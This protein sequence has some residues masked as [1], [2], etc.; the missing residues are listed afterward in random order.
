MKYLYYNI[1]RNILKNIQNYI[2]DKTQFTCFL[3]ENI[4]S[5][6]IFLQIVIQ[7]I[8]KMQINFH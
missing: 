7:L 4:L 3:P 6:Q 8:I 5:L 1:L 2:K